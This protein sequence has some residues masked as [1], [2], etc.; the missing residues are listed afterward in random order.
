[1]TLAGRQLRGGLMGLISS[2]V[3]IAEDQCPGMRET[4]SDSKVRY[5]TSR[6]DM[7]RGI[8]RE[9]AAEA[10]AGLVAT[11]KSC[12]F[13]CF[14]RRAPPFAMKSLHLVARAAVNFTCDRVHKAIF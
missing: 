12:I 4:P 3:S 1:M 7:K 9:G 8:A 14:S 11:K 5:I 6:E 13:S 10:R 2:Q